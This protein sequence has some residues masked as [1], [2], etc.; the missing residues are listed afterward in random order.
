MDEGKCIVCDNWQLHM[1]SRA[2]TTHLPHE[3]LY[4]ERAM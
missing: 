3:E 2:L 4:A 1:H